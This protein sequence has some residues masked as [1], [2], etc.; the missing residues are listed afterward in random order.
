MNYVIIKKELIFC[1]QI[2]LIEEVETYY[3]TGLQVTFIDGST[4]FIYNVSLKDLKDLKFSNS[5][6]FYEENKRWTW[7]WTSNV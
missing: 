6:L 5:R 7:K 1:N 4:R 2:K 3:T